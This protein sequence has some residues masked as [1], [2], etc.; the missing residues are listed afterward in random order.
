MAMNG[1]VWYRKIA[2]HPTRRL[3]VL[4]AFFLILLLF[5]GWDNRSLL[6]RIRESVINTYIQSLS[7]GRFGTGYGYASADRV[8]FAQ[9]EPGDIILGGWP[10]CAYGRFSHVGLYVGS[11]QV[12]EGYVD[13]GLNLQDLD[14][15]R[16][17]SEVCLL[18]VNASQEVK[19]RA[20]AYALARQ[21]QLFYPVAFKPGERYWNCS[22]IIWRAYK[23]QGLDLDELGD[24]W[25]APESFTA[26][27]YV[28][29]LYEKGTR[30]I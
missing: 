14:H 10:N 2:G 13:Y 26:S 21:G 15:Y 30:Y 11:N 25:I 8:S 16:D 23:N 1:K 7:H 3:L 17:Y 18:R 9:L 20:V 4:P 29:I 27:R 24:L 5:I 19:D 12:L 6:P 28:K 22:K